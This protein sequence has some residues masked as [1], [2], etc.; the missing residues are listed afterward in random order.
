MEALLSEI[1]RLTDGM[2]IIPYRLPS[3][4]L[5]GFFIGTFCLVMWC[6]VIGEFT[7]SVAIRFNRRHITALKKEIAERESLSIQ[8]YTAGDRAGY[9]ALNK[10]ANDA[11]GRHFFT[12]AAYSAGMLWPL[13]FALAWMQTRFSAVEFAFPDSLP[14]LS[15]YAVGYPFFFIPLYILA[16]ILF[17]RLRSRLPYFRGVHKMLH[18][19]RGPVE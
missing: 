9:K 8:A 12:M 6:V 14:W 17:G 11:W 19:S 10:Q 13:P 1:L 7:L 15:G 5:L 4:P 16:R 2:L 3:N 18:E